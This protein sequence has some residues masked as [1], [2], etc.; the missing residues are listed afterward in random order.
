MADITDRLQHRACGGWYGVVR[1]EDVEGHTSIEV[2]CC[3]RCK[4]ETMQPDA[5]Y[6]QEVEH[7]A[8]EHESAPSLA[9]PLCRSV[10]DDG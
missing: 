1:T 7:M 6:P 8:L 3:D 4:Q 2:W 9:C 5:I 10:E